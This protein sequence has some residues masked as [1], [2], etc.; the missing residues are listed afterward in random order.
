MQLFKGRKGGDGM[1]SDE[2]EEYDYDDM[3]AAGTVTYPEKSL[4]LFF[5]CLQ[6]DEMI[7]Y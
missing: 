4:F 3:D 7:H 2:E 1:Q 5:C 6:H